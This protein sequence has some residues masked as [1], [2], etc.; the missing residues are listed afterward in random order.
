VAARWG[1]AKGDGS[2]RKP[3]EE[4]ATIILATTSTPYSL[5]P[6]VVFEDAE[7]E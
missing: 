6:T 1:R 7:E 5:N 2:D 4:C 3:P